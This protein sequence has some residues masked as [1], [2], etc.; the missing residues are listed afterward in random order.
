MTYRYGVDK[1]NQLYRIDFKK[2]KRQRLKGVFKSEKDNRLSYWLNAPSAWRRKYNLPRKI[3]FEGKWRLD[4][5][6][7]LQLTLAE[8]KNQR[9][10]DRLSLKGDI[11]SASGD[12]FV[13]EIVSRQDD[14]ATSTISLLTLSGKWKQDAYNRLTFEVKEAKDPDVLTLVGE[15]EVN[16]YQQITYT[17]T[18]TELKRKTKYLRTIV[19]EGYWDITES[20]RVRYILN[21]GSKSVFDFRV[22]LESPSLYPK[23]GLIKYRVG[24][25]L[26]KSTRYVNRILCLYG[27]W[28]F[29]RFGTLRFD[30][31]YRE[32][33][34]RGT[35]FEIE[36]RLSAQNSLALVLKNQEE[37]PL[38][39]T[40]VFTRKFLASNDGEAFVR[41]KQ[42][43]EDSRAVEAGIKLR[44]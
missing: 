22:Q 18:R 41:L 1:D 42:V 2:K 30:M 6:H 36:K 33:R 38:G 17:Y 19:F 23:K 31:E 9:A 12:S 25:G 24:I 28:K 27:T 21:R 26:R 8:T 11:I 4:Q 16:T 29:D 39:M 7:N 13:F 20:R 15:W 40:L 5:A 14:R 44:F 32:G 3:T 43:L 35:S 34:V 37:K 10:G